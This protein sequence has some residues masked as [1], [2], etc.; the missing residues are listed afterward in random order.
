M[1]KASGPLEDYE[2]ENEW[3]KVMTSYEFDIQKSYKLSVSHSSYPFKGTP[4][5][6]SNSVD[7]QDER[8]CD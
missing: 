3:F 7:L 1:S 8:Q 4:L 2:G 6:F 5:P